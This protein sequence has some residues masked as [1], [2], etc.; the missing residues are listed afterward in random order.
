MTLI[1]VQASDTANY[2]LVAS[3]SFGSTTSSVAA[4]SVNLALPESLNPG[5]TDP[6][7][8][9]AIQTTERFSSADAFHRLPDSRATASPNWC[10]AVRSQASIRVRVPKPRSTASA[11][12]R[13]KKLLS[14]ARLPQSAGNHEPISPGSMLMAVWTAHSMRQ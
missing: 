4:L 2:T 5:I 7:M 12:R 6:V 11:F 14:A 8:A 1:N 9:T 13:I 10:Q 3:N